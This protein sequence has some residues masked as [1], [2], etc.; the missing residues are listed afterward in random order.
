L[1]DNTK[2]HTHPVAPQPVDLWSS[3][4]IGN[5]MASCQS[6]IKRREMLDKKEDIACHTV[7]SAM[8]VLEASCLWL[9]WQEINQF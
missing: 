9:F 7:V 3:F 1:G 4:E 6:T 2:K 5:K 8:Q